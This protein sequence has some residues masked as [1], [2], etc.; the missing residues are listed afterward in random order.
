IYHY[1]ATPDLHRLPARAAA[2]DPRRARP[3]CGSPPLPAGFQ[4]PLRLLGGGLLGGRRH[5]ALLHRRQRP[6]SGV[7]VL[8]RSPTH[9]APEPRTG[10]RFHAAPR[11]VAV[12]LGAGHAPHETG[13]QRWNLA[14]GKFSSGVIAQCYLGSIGFGVAASFGAPLALARF[15][16]SMDGRSREYPPERGRVL[17]VSQ[18]YRKTIFCTALA[19]SLTSMRATEW[20]AYSQTVRPVTTASATAIRWPMAGSTFLPI[21]SKEEERLRPRLVLSSTLEGT[22]RMRGLLERL[23]A[24][25]LRARERASLRENRSRG[26]GPQG[27]SKR[28]ATRAAW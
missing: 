7:D 8:D 3:T 4:G 9:R 6:Q 17:A 1:G 23:S 5:A 22:K 2:R 21:S 14:G 19:R 28:S 18:P 20:G 13:W 16:N 15:W 11:Q 27:R 25:A 26:E 12:L 10:N 24:R